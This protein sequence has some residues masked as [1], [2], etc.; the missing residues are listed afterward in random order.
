MILAVHAKAHVIYKYNTG[1]YIKMDKSV[2][3]WYFEEIISEKF[4]QK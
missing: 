4:L 3:Y 1:I 2:K